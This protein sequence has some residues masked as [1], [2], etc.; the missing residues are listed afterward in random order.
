[1]SMQGLAMAA[2]SLARMSYT[3]STLFAGLAAAML[4]KLQ[5]LPQWARPLPRAGSGVQ[6]QQQ[7]QQQQPLQSRAVKY[8]QL[9][10]QQHH[11]QSV[12]PGAA[13]SVQLQQLHPPPPWN[14]W[15]DDA[16]VA[17]ASLS[18]MARVLACMGV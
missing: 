2:H 10:P 18:S 6:Q 15:A 12:T 14:G 3:D 17:V 4:T 9:Q 1:M 16:D 11:H 13:R 5:P 8:V 7:Q